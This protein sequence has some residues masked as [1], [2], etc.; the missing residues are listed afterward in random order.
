MFNFTSIKEVQE[1][2][3]LWC[4]SLRT[5]ENMSQQEL[6]EELGVS[7]LTI[8]NVENGKN[9]TIDSL[10]KILQ[11]FGQLEKFNQ[12]AKNNIINTKSFY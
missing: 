6:A 7:R 12:W 9:F 10:L 2:L 4:K 8:A 3:G 11:H 1:Q 5:N